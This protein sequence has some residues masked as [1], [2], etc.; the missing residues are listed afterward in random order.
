[1][2]DAPYGYSH[3]LCDYTGHDC[4]QREHQ[5]HHDSELAYNLRLCDS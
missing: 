1:M 5:N 2:Q 3:L 4:S